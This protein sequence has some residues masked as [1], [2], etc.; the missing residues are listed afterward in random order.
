MISIFTDLTERSP[1]F[2]LA[3]IDT[4]S[5]PQ[6]SWISMFTNAPN[7]YDAWVRFLG[8]RFTGMDAAIFEESFR[9]VEDKELRHRAL[10][11]LAKAGPE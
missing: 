7:Q 10:T 6:K 11:S 2:G 3:P 1:T 4:V 9:A 5:G 8:R